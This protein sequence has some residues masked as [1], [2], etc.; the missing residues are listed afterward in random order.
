M[1]LLDGQ[2]VIKASEEFRSFANHLNNTMSKID[3][4]ISTINGGALRGS[5]VDALNKRYEEIKGDALS[6]SKLILNLGDTIE[7][8]ARRREGINDNSASAL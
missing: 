2:N 6:F 5:A 8:T 1:V 4:E 3:G 7:T